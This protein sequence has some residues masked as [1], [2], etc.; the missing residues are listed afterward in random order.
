MTSA[1]FSPPPAREP[2]T[3]RFSELLVHLLHAGLCSS[4]AIYYAIVMVERQYQRKVEDL[5]PPVC[6][7]TRRGKRRPGSDPISCKDKGRGAWANRPRR[8]P[9]CSK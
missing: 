8:I 4:C 2:E 7:G 5:A 1:L 9:A 6:T 3:A